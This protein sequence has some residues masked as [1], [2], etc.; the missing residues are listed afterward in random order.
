MV[1]GARRFVY[2]LHKRIRFTFR[3]CSN[4]WIE[5]RIADPKLFL[6]LHWNQVRESGKNPGERAC[7]DIPEN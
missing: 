2:R 5:V 7:T 4:I 3:H 6:Y 1:I